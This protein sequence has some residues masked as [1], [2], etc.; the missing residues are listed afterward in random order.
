[1]LDGIVM[2]KLGV[3]TAVVC[4]APFVSSGK[5]MAV[6][7]GFPGYPFVVMP[8]PINATTYETLDSWVENILSEIVRLLSP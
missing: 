7:H 6:A 4:T 3:P 2:E 8:H 1:L 5:A